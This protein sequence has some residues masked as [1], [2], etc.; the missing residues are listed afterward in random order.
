MNRLLRFLKHRSFDEADVRRVLPDAVLTRLEQRVHASEKK[1]TGEIR[2][3][4]EAGLPASYVWKRLA[5]RD[6][7]LSMFGRLRVWDTE[8]N[9]GVLIYLL[10]AEHK[11]EIVADRGLNARVADDEW[12][13]I[14]ERMREPLRAGHF[15]DGL[16]IAIDEVEAL[17][18]RH[19]A[20]D[21]AAINPN[22]LPNQPWIR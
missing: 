15:E 7:A 5:A 16:N 1:H 3:C 2:L 11:I 4:I 10:F 19:F 8:H 22:E 14:V 21:A 9:N 13:R 17:L 18:E 6:R 12:K 20:V